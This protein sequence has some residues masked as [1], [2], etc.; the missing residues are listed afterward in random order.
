MHHANFYQR[1]A[2]VYIFTER[3]PTALND[4]EKLEKKEKKIFQ[5]TTTTS[6]NQSTLTA[7]YILTTNQ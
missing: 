7:P 4:R 1:C 6:I 5:V 2:C 3:S